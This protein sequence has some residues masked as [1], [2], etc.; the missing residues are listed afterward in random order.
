MS[1]RPRI[2]WFSP[3]DPTSD[4]VADYSTR[5]I[6]PELRNYFEIELFTDRKLPP[7]LAEREDHFLNARR[8]HHAA[9]FDLFVYNIED[10]P[11]ARFARAHLGLIPGVVWL[12]EAA[13]GDF[14]AEAFHASPWELTV[15]QF[16]D[17]GA[18]FNPRTNPIHPLWPFAYRERALSTLLLSSSPAVLK[19]LEGLSGRRL[20]ASPGG[21]QALHVPVPATL[22]RVI[23]P[24]EKSPILRVAS[25]ARPGVEGQMHKVFP[26]LKAQHSGWLLT[27]MIDSSELV[28]A[29]RVVEEFAVQTQVELRV[30]RS[31]Q[32]W[33][34]ILAETTLAL[35]L[36]NS[37][38]YRTSPYLEL[39]LL[40]GRPAVVS[41]HPGFSEI[42]EDLVFRIDP[43]MRGAAELQGIF[44]AVQAGEP[45]PWAARGQAA[46][47]TQ[48]TPAQVGQTLRK[49]F[50]EHIPDYAAIL[51]RWNGVERR[52]MAGLEGEIQELLRDHSGATVSPA[53]QIL[54]PFFQEFGGLKPH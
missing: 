4:S 12:H 14:G 49:I 9:P 36:H 52:G 18:P 1:A 29:R 39:S 20:E 26:A 21:H 10:H 22:S 6:L 41:N 5:Q 38:F 42:S 33:E 47:S 2:A 8:R 16:L 34:E 23:P 50:T 46:L 54:A 45:A 30:G 19:R 32:R 35:H 37:P 25:P 15:E 7:G 27:W 13:I 44:E 40:A 53:E 17:P 48:H 24:P 3:L 51:A 28:A 11:R 31:P 43:S